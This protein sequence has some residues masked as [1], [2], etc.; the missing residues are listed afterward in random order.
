[1]TLCSTNT[2]L[3]D[4]WAFAER[5]TQYY[6]LLDGLGDLERLRSFFADDASWESFDAGAEEPSLRFPSIN[7]LHELVTREG[8]LIRAARERH[9]ITGL[10]TESHGEGRARSLLKVLLTVQPDPRQPPVIRET[11]L[12][13]CEWTERDGEWL[14]QHWR[15]SRDTIG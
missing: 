7:D 9:H 2:E 5:L 3:I 15:V 1:M 6:L 4:H 14:I 8:H 10:V 13:T 12:V 11:A